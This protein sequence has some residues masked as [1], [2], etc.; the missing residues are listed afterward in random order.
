MRLKMS[1]DNSVI[2]ETYFAFKLISKSECTFYDGAESCLWIDERLAAL[3]SC[4]QTSADGLEELL[5]RGWLLEK[6]LP[7]LQ[8]EFPAGGFRTVATGEDDP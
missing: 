6:V 2:K 4:I 1:P 7:V 8:Q 5:R 3:A